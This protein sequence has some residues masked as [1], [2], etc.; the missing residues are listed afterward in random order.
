VHRR[1]PRSRLTVPVL[2][3][4]W[5]TAV[6]VLT[7]GCRSDPDRL[8]AEEVPVPVGERATLTIEY[9]GST[10]WADTGS[11]A[12]VRCD[13]WPADDPSAR[14]ELRPHYTDTRNPI[15]I[16]RDGVEYHSVGRFPQS[17]GEVVVEC[18]GPSDADLFAS[19]TR[20]SS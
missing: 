14:A 7:A 13:A 17:S 11:A 1:T 8:A 16:E 4:T 15:P 2:L 18:S 20:P 5:L 3:V 6:A 9:G 12:E 19:L 10:M